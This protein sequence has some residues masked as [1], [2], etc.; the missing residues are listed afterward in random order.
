MEKGYIKLWR[1]IGDGEIWSAPPLVLKLFLYLLTHCDRHTGQLR[2]SM[3]S[4]ADRN[5][6]EENKSPRI[7]HRQTIR[8]ALQWLIDADMV[9][10]EVR[11]TAHHKYTNITI[12]NW[13]AYQ[14]DDTEPVTRSV[15]LQEDSVKESDI[16]REIQND[17]APPQN[18]NSEKSEGGGSA[19]AAPPEKKQQPEPT[20]P[21][22]RL[23]KERTPEEYEE[24]QLCWYDGIGHYTRSEVP[25]DRLE[26][27]MRK[28]GPSPVV[29]ALHKC[30]EVE[31]RHP[32]PYFV[33]VLNSSLSP[34]PSLGK[35]K[36]DLMAPR[37]LPNQR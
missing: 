16:G 11:G 14:C 8:R 21:F 32:W 1:C 12:C 10:L 13:E 3:A 34:K 29:D 26:P 9:K 7:P 19:I 2:T 37:F 22:A 5:Q 20:H 35:G 25:W 23:V 27:I 24:I 36:I 15:H 31:V 17:D 6:W 4:L 30:M 28:H 18:D 33:K